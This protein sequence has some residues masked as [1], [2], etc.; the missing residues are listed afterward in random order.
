MV[1]NKR[2][3]NNGRLKGQTRLT[4]KNKPDPN[5]CLAKKIVTFF[6]TSD[7]LEIFRF[8]TV[9]F[10]FNSISYRCL[11]SRPVTLSNGLVI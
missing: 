6:C 11:N 5:I 9:I 2:I 3:N 4:R 1:N 8:T 10:F 7:R